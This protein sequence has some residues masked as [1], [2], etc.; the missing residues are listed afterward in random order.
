MKIAILGGGIAGLST[1]IALQKLGYEYTVYEAAKS[2]APV[3]AGLGL[4]ANAIKA[5]EHLGIAEEVIA[6]GRE[7]ESFD[8]LDRKG[9]LITKT[10]TQ[11]LND[12]FGLNNFTIH[13]AR[14]HEVLLDY[15]DGKRLQ[16]NKRCTHIKSDIHGLE[17]FFEDGSVDHSD[18]LIVA[19]GIHS[20]VRK[21]LVPAS[22]P[23]YSGY[24][25]WRGVLN[26]PTKGL[27]SSES[28][29]KE[30]RF[31]IVPLDD[32]LLY[33]FACVNARQNDQSLKAYGA[34]EIGKLFQSFHEPIP[35]IIAATQNHEI[36]WGDI[37]DLKPLPQYAFGKALLIGDAAH[38]T[39]PNMGQGACQA[40]EDAAWLKTLLANSQ[41]LVEV[42]KRFEEI[43][44]KRTHW[45]TKQSRSIG[46]V[47]QLSSPVLVGLR[48]GL[49]RLLPESL[50]E[51]QLKRLYD[52][53]F[54]G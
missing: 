42:F 28:W 4:G 31:G 13:R 46:S 43:R 21:Q 53:S 12:Q 37:F 18:Y 45:I 44:L 19:D 27:Q 25:C 34:R 36:I 32:N 24:T 1:A 47:A 22:Q 49:F 2:I 48:D 11:R 33:W 26:Y 8:I 29:G 3:G 17:L 16:L 5:L 41:D 7:L 6:K 23:R 35:S 14:L 50:N 9:K 51:K 10:D 54:A 20:N 40:L 52:V 39:T 38:A 15:I 30:G